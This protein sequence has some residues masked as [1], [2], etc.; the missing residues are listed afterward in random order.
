MSGARPTAILTLVA[1]LATVAQLGCGEDGDEQAK[2][3]FV[4]RASAICERNKENAGRAV[5]RALPDL[6]FT[7][8][9]GRE[10]QRLLE[11]ALVHI[12]RSGAE[13]DELEPPPGDEDVIDAYLHSYR[14]ATAEMEA[15]ATDR[16]RT[17]DLMRGTI[18]DPFTEA[19][20]M[21]GEYGVEKCSGDDA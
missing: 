17:T 9:S 10:A 14:A 18:V 3:E 20:Q 2:A 19:D 11:V 4:R 12:R 1:V 6:G 7:P 16:A 8:P 5:E 15:I 13:I 21:L